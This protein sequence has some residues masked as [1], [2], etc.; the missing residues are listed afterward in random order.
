MRACMHDAWNFQASHGMS[1]AFKK[2]NSVLPC[3]SP[4]QVLLTLSCPMWVYN[5]TGLPI[6]L[7][8]TADSPTAA[9]WVPPTP[10]DHSL[11]AL[12]SVGACTSH[13]AAL[14]QSVSA[15]PSQQLHQPSSASQRTS[16]SCFSQLPSNLHQAV[17]HG[18]GL[19]S[20]CGEPT[21][22]TREPSA[23]Q[24]GSARGSA[25]GPPGVPRRAHQFNVRTASECAE[26]LSCL[27]RVP[28]GLGLADDR[29]RGRSSVRSKVW[30][31]GS[32]SAPVSGSIQG[33]NGGSAGSGLAQGGSGPL[34]PCLYGKLQVGTFLAR[35]IK[36]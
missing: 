10:L 5:C 3:A 13:R 20:L 21:S 19:A 29:I 32:G 34:L 24:P 35:C 16:Y 23:G 1:S 28:S 17:S 14:Q 31:I 36:P 30:S 27:Q 4:S 18:V 11:H 26:S 33:Q 6:A 22:S 9:A 25:R 2:L 8:T 7:R 12:A 15:D